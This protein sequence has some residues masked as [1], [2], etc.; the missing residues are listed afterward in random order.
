MTYALDY[1]EPFLNLTQTVDPASNRTHLAW[2]NIQGAT[3]YYIFKVDKNGNIVETDM[4]LTNSWTDNDPTPNPDNLV[5]YEVS[6]GGIYN[7]DTAVKSYDRYPPAGTPGKKGMTWTINSVANHYWHIGWTPVPG[8]T[9]YAVRTVQQTSAPT[10]W[11]SVP[12]TAQTTTGTDTYIALSGTQTTWAIVQPLNRYGNGWFVS[13][14]GVPDGNVAVTLHQVKKDDL[15]KTG[16]GYELTTNPDILAKEGLLMAGT[17]AIAGGLCKDG[18]SPLLIKIQWVQP[19]TTHNFKIV[20]NS[21]SS[22]LPAVN[23]SIELLINGAWVKQNTWDS[24]QGSNGDP[25]MF[26]KIG[27]F[28]RDINATAFLDDNFQVV[29]SDVYTYDSDSE[30]FSIANPPLVLVHGYTSDEYTWGDNFMGVINPSYDNGSRIQKIAYG[31]TM[32]ERLFAQFGINHTT[33]KMLDDSQNQA[34]SFAT[35]APML[36]AELTEN[37]EAASSVLHQNWAFINYDVV[38]H[39]QGGVLTRMLCSPNGAPNNKIPP[40]TQNGIPRFNR[41]ITLGSPHNG[42]RI[43]KYATGLG[44][45]IRTLAELSSIIPPKFYPGSVDYQLANSIGC[46]PLAKIHAVGFT[47]HNKKAP[48]YNQPYRYILFELV[49]FYSQRQDG[50]DLGG[51]VATNDCDGIVHLESQIGDPSNHYTL[52]TNEPIGHADIK[53][54]LSTRFDV[55]NPLVPVAASTETSSMTSALTIAELLNG[56]GDNFGTFTTAPNG[57]DNT[58]AILSQILSQKIKPI[59]VLGLISPATFTTVVIGGVLTVVGT[60]SWTPSPASSVVAKGTTDTTP[61]TNSWLLTLYDND[62]PKGINW[63]AT[64]TGPNTI[65]FVYPDYTIEGILTAVAYTWSNNAIYLSDEVVIYSNTPYAT[66]KNITFDIPAYAA[67]GDIISA[68]CL[69]DYGTGV[70]LPVFQTATLTTTN[71]Q[72]AMQSGNGLILLRPGIATV[73]ATLG[74]NTVTQQV[75]ITGRIL[76][77]VPPTLQILSPTNN[78]HATNSV[79]LNGTASDDTAVA[80]VFYQLNAGIPT[81]ATTTNSWTN[82][83]AVVS[84]P[85]PGTNSLTA[86]AVDSSGNQSTNTASI[87]VIVTVL[88]KITVNTNGLGTISPNYNGQSLQVGKSYTMAAAAGTGFTFAGWTGT[89]TTNGATITFLMQTNTALTANFADTTKPTLVL[90]TPTAGQRWSNSVF[91]ATGTASDNWQL[92]SVNYS[93]NRQAWTNAS[94]VGT[95]WTAS[96]NLTP[97]TNTLFAYAADAAGNKS[98]TNNVSLQYVVT[99]MLQIHAFGLGS[100]SPNYSNAWLEVGRAYSITATPKANFIVTNWTVS[101][102]WIGGT[103]TNTTTMDFTMASNLTLFVDFA[104]TVKP[105]V[106]ITY[107]AANQKM[108]NAVANLTGTASDAWGVGGLWFQINSNGWIA[109]TTT[110]GFTNWAATAT[111]TLGTNSIKAFAQNLG[112]NFSA[113]NAISITSSN[114]F[115]LLMT[116]SNSIVVGTNGI[117]FGL[118]ISKNLNG[119]IQFSTNL[120]D[121]QTLTNFTGTSTNVTFRDPTATNSTR[122]FYRAVIP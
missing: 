76:D 60:T 85:T 71:T 39:S 117:S 18:I 119:H 112:Y 118:D 15:I 20:F 54:T 114:T 46:D 33:S 110:N 95:N 96:L 68:K 93:L 56:M 28:D 91:T 77:S 55:N 6:D 116:M 26:A 79:I 4:S 105:T 17:N 115:R 104:E 66:P 49:G 29:A 63:D 21:I 37:V 9:G 74:T 30:N 14:S 11:L 90:K 109:V 64:I 92:A 75:Q 72:L 7:Y 86:Y 65:S 98:A 108:T 5:S 78:V 73:T 97:G 87:K 111:L 101:T 83:T 12:I 3:S 51:I 13:L 69:G 84:I 59:M 32:I 50:I 38:G 23:N 43:A 31:T 121:W 19:T 103:V 106:V 48:D 53:G 2:R 94:L 88:A 61:V 52:I 67:T 107:P 82:W 35:L 16:S 58:N 36:D 122:R 89:A 120:V 42:S 80:S 81:L 45:L 102:N 25:V 44:S 24:T 34:Y 10:N 57:I 113:T 99:N 47:L 8:A 27:P 40:F 62:N 1:I 70:P 100:I 22:M 41:V